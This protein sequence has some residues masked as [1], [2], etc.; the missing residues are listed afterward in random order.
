[1]TVITSRGTVYSLFP[2]TN[3]DVSTVLNRCTLYYSAKRLVKYIASSNMFHNMDM[4]SDVSIVEKIVNAIRE[5]DVSIRDKA[6]KNC[7]AYEVY[8]ALTQ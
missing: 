7:N 6:Y 4:V 5:E 3:G 1:M 8:N 2:N